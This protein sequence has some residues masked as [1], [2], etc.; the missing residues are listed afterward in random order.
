[1]GSKGKNKIKDAFDRVEP[2]EGAEQRMYQS[3][4]EKS[5][6]R[7]KESQT[8][9]WA[10]A[11]YPTVRRLL[12]LAACLVLIVAAGALALNIDRIYNG[13]DTDPPIMVG[14]PIQEVDGCGDFEPLGFTIDA[15]TGS[16][17]TSYYIMDGSIARVNFSR[18]G[19]VYDYSASKQEGDFS[20]VCG[21]T[22]SSISVVPQYNG[23]LELIGGSV[24][25]A[26]WSNGDITYY[27]CN[28]DG[29]DETEITALVAL[30]AGK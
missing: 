30:L 13:D 15:P 2:G 3:I 23:V 17:E 26:S 8:G 7:Q 5:S 10:K 24:W 11:G 28:S 12:P 4:L 20:G 1:M 14:S 22:V 29:A 18:D 21:E 19:H 27:L 9:A 6:R 25:R 16:S